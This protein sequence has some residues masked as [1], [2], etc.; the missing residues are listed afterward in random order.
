[1]GV[2]DIKFYL[3]RSMKSLPKLRFASKYA[4]YLK[5]KN[6]STLIARSHCSMLVS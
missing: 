1:M 2:Q 4:L 5:N 6:G 3:Q